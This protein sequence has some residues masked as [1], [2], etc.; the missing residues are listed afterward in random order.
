MAKVQWCMGVAIISK[1]DNNGVRVVAS[2]VVIR[3]QRF[4]SPRSLRLR[5]DYH[6]RVAHDCSDILLEKHWL[7]M[8]ITFWVCAGAFAELSC[9]QTVKRKASCRKGLVTMDCD[10]HFSW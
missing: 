2:A 1:N 7:Q 3:R 4:P 5:Y 8:Y 9:D 6:L 10:S